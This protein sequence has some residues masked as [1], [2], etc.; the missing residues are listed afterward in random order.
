MSTYKGSLGYR[1]DMQEILLLVYEK[2]SSVGRSPVTQSLITSL[3]KGMTPYIT[4][5]I[6]A[7]HRDELQDI[8][9]LDGVEYYR[10]SEDLVSKG[11]ALCKNCQQWTGSTE[12]GLWADLVPMV[13]AH[14][15]REEFMRDTKIAW[16]LDTAIHP[17]LD[18]P[19]NSYFVP[20]V[21]YGLRAGVKRGGNPKLSRRF[22][23]AIPTLTEPS[24]TPLVNEGRSFCFPFLIWERKSDSGETLKAENQLGLPTVKALDVLEGLGLGDIPIVGLTTVGAAWQVWVGHIC[25]PQNP[26]KKVTKFSNELGNYIDIT[27]ISSDWFALVISANY[28]VQSS[29]SEF[30]A[31]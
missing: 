14:F 17:G 4:S 23:S 16:K 2:I 25:V 20:D 19:F 21:I 10:A 9:V 3:W 15:T 27:S 18:S 30:G 6:I 8:N 5:D 24:F 1:E 22:F 26:E 29:F 31:F 11:I 12:D 7:N 28:M 13:S